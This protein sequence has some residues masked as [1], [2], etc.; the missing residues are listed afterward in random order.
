MALPKLKVPEYELVV[1]STQEK[2][3]YRPFL[4]REEKILL[5]ALE[6]DDQNSVSNALSTIVTECTFGNI[7][8]ET[9]PVFD[10]EY[11]FLQVRSKSVGETA[12]LS[13]VCPDDGKTR[14]DVTI[15]YDKV[16]VQMSVDHTNEIELTDDIKMVMKYP[17]LSSLDGF[18]EKDETEST[19][20]MMQNCVDEIHFGDDV[21]RRVDMSDKELSEFFNDMTSEMF[22]KVQVF[23]TTM[24]KLRHIL[25]I[26]N[27]KTK[28]KSEYM[29]EGLA[30]FFI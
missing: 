26:K 27:P 10:A 30:D 12:T 17:T 3:K 8:G 24:P 21:Y 16:G 2:I 23:F 13:V 9:A 1:P 25:D 4:V 28:K 5:M 22:A 18:D 15:E 7:D 6:N 29:L 11:I 20:R 14:V 19:L